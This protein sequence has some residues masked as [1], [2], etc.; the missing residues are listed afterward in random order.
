L[1][2]SY[3]IYSLIA[4][5]KKYNKILSVFILLFIIFFAG[6]QNI[7]HADN[8]IRIKAESFKYIRPAGE[9]IRSNSNSGDSIL[10]TDESAS[11]FYFSRR[12]ILLAFNVS[13]FEDL[14]ASN[15]PRY[16][17]MSF[18]YAP[19]YNNPKFLEMVNQVFNDRQ[20]F[21]MVKYFGPPIDAEGRIPI[22][23]IFEVH[24]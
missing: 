9:W 11:Y 13:H 10:V 5:V 15:N 18:Y 3:F 2:A 21:T 6:Y 22:V 16:L 24:Y 20:R 8:T 7:T 4:Y 19:N 14:I 12:N 1:I 17:V 23:S